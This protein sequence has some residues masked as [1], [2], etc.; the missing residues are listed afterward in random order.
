MATLGM[1]RILIPEI[2]VNRTYVHDLTIGLRNLG[3]E[4]EVASEAFWAGPGRHDILLWLWPEGFFR[5]SL[6]GKLRL[7]T[8]HLKQDF[9][10]SWRHGKTPCPPCGIYT[11]G[12]HAIAK[13]MQDGIGL[14]CIRL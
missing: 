5:H 6:G 13:E 4:V 1:M 8:D 14:I 10:N 12:C 3:H 9:F 2:W 7:L 11:T